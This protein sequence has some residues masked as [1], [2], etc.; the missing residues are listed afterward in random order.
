MGFRVRV[1]CAL[2]LAMLVSALGSTG[3]PGAAAIRFLDKT[4]DRQLNLEPG[5][6]TAVAPE[7]SPNKRDE[8]ARRLTR[9]ADDLTHGSLEVAAVKLDG[10]MAAV[11]IRK[12]DGLD[13]ASQR[14]FAVA[15]IKRG[16]A[17]LA[18]PVPA[19]FENTGL[20][21]AG[22]LRQRA[23]MLQDWM[24]REQVTE[25]ASLREKT[26]DR[27][28]STI[29][30]SI[31]TDAL[32]K[33]DSMKVCER[34]LAA[35]ARQSLPE[36][37]GLLGGLS[38]NPPE[39]W[40]LRVKSATA[41]VRSPEPK[42]P[43][44]L[45]VSKDVVRVPVAH[46]E[47]AGQ[48]LVSI[49]CLDPVASSTRAVPGIELVHLE[50]SKAPDGLWR[51]DPPTSF[52]EE[53]QPDDEPMDASLDADLLADFPGRL[54]AAYPPAAEPSARAA[55][56]TLFHHLHTGDFPSLMR[57]MQHGGK[58]VEPSISAA[59]AWWALREPGGIRRLVPLAFREDGQH[60]AAV[61]QLFS[62]RSPDRLDLKV[63]HF[64]KSARGWFWMP[65]PS[66]ELEKTGNQW[67]N[68]QGHLW[69]DRLTEDCVL[70]PNLPDGPAPSEDEARA[71]VESW[72][73]ATAAGDVSAA[74]RVA[75]RLNTP[76]STTAV[77]RN[78][79]YEMNGIRKNDQ[80]SVV[81]G[82]HRGAIWTAVSVRSTS[83]HKSI[84]PLYPVVSTSA[85]PRIAIEIDLI[86][87]QNR[88]RE[89]LNRAALDRLRDLPKAA[90]E[91]KELFQKHQ[92]GTIEAAKP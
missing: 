50:I 7:T 15:M 25:L 9:L 67:A 58:S 60:A 35:C 19:S 49:A 3:D 12:D 13:P 8:I 79:G 61:C 23:D 29:A 2:W 42:H 31:S 10:G 84:Y 68:E 26:A 33:L 62:T 85:G 48:A 71:V 64:E 46:E 39:D 63:F 18:A 51:I 1:L 17:W 56:E 78:L 55:R 22:D 43:W 47:S 38:A 77:L 40:A 54:A 37:L 6:D 72:L 87:S 88:T 32:R 34:F 52:L 14:V 86:A 92:A 73:R 11:L 70:L 59:R 66:P 45:L 36:V 74:L 82:I 28:R 41:A 76:K 16:E 65:Q 69:Q 27:L 53:I 4:R 24:L 89:F 20:G 21:Y 81:T 91:L 5:G 80:P 83:D 44:R 90:A 30:Q 75:A 57:L